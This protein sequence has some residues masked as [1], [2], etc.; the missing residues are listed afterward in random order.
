M[1]EITPIGLN[2]VFTIVNTLLCII[3]LLL[4]MFYYKKNPQIDTLINQ[5]IAAA[6]E[7][8]RQSRKLDKL[9]IQS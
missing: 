5:A 6:D 4:R 3:L 7:F 8:K 9:N 1:S 2:D